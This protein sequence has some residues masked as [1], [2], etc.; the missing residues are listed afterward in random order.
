MFSSRTVYQCTF[1]LTSGNIDLWLHKCSFNFY[2]DSPQPKERNIFIRGSYAEVIKIIAE[3]NEHENHL[4]RISSVG[5][6]DGM[7]S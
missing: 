6:I 4:H 3:K 5:Q 7:F 2:E 1:F